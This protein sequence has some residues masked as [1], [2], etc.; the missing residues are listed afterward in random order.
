MSNLSKMKETGFIEI[1]KSLRENT[2]I[3]SLD[4]SKNSLNQTVMHELFSSLADNYVI[5]E[6]ILD[7]KLKNL[8]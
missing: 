3:L 7:I 4:L 2:S 6:V 5:C 1:A 8:P